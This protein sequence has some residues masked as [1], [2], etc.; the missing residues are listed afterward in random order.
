MLKVQIV[1]S[2]EAFCASLASILSDAFEVD[3]CSD[4]H[5][6]PYKIHSFQ[7]DILIMETI[8]PGNDGFHILQTVQAAGLYPVVLMITPLL[9]DYII[10]Y[11][12][13]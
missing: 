5:L 2:S 1:D 6:A 7:P 9:T 12:F 13:Y 8:L 10:L 3:T 11:I 4:G